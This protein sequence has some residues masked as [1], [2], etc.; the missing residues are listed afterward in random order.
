MHLLSITC[1][2]EKMPRH[3]SYGWRIGN[4]GNVPLLTNLP[5]WLAI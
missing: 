4:S 2:E 5:V 3:R 1:G